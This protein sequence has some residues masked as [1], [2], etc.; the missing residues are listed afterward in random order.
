MMHAVREFF[1][2][3]S[4]GSYRDPRPETALHTGALCCQPVAFSVFTLPVFRDVG[5]GRSVGVRV[6]EVADPKTP[7]EWAEDALAGCTARRGESGYR[8]TGARC[9]CRRCSAERRDDLMAPFDE[10]LG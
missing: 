8:R 4:L 1:P 3:R 7:I 2:V 6:R 5:A 9:T 10:T